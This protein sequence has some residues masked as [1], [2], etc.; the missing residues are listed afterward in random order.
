MNSLQ[1]HKQVMLLLN[2]DQTF[3][4]FNES[5]D[6]NSVEN[7][8]QMVMLANRTLNI[9]ALTHWGRVTYICVS[10]LT[11]TGSDNGL[12]PG[13]HQAII[14]AN[15]G[16]LLIGPLGINFSEILIE[17]N[18]FSFKKM[19]LKMSSGKWQQF[20]LGLSVLKAF[21]IMCLCLLWFVSFYIIS[22]RPHCG[23]SL[24]IM[25]AIW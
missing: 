11:I 16:I 13:W 18:T 1:P 3:K 14:W 6:K 12:S 25:T 7:V 9:S 22:R 23:L 10:N 2:T 8:A 20:C 21:P 17:I 15:A 19:P 24:F 5:G 4:Q